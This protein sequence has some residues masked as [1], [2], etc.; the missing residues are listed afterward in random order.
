[1]NRRLDSATRRQQILNA[2]IR[3][4]AAKG[5]QAA[6]M[7]EIVAASGLSK[8]GVYWHFASKDAIIA[9][10]FE[11]FFVAELEGAAD[12]LARQ[13]SA[14]DKLLALASQLGQGV[15]DLAQQ[16]PSPHEFY[17]AAIRNEALTQILESYFIVYRQQLID[18]VAEG[19]A[20]GEWRTVD[21][22][23]TAVTL[24]GLFE[25][26]LLVWSLLPDTFDLP[27][28]IDAAVRLLLDGL[29]PSRPVTVDVPGG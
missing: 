15:A 11:Q 22:A 16:F 21:P 18:L 29:Q 3:V 4:I 7:D 17:V 9:G 6:T 26:I 8:G 13:A 23:T 1:M 10:L 14:A 27:E 19:M 24:M 20:R 12:L 25:G 2:A 5:F 28:Q